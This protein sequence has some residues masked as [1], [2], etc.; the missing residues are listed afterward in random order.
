MIKD[1]KMNNFFKFTSLFFNL[2]S[3]DDEVNAK[4]LNF[5][6][7]GCMQLSPIAIDAGYAKKWNIT[8]RQN[9]Y[10]CMTKN[11]QLLRPTLYRMGGLCSTSD[12]K[13][14]YFLLI[15][16]VEAFYA[17]S[18]TK[19]PL[20]KPH[21]EGRWCIIDQNGDEKVEFSQFKS[22]HIIKNSV[23]Y[24][25]D[26]N[27]YNIETGAFYGHANKTVESTDFLFLSKEY[28]K[29]ETQRGV[30]KINKLTGDFELFK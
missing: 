7:D 11:G 20:R 13:K 9:D 23:I 28:D 15:K 29:D 26:Q 12:L 1:N 14:T 2:I 5:G 27:Y 30:L 16:H 24:S 6:K 22:P 10:L 18:I 4:P 3:F 19:D 21:M 17:D 8:D 25:I